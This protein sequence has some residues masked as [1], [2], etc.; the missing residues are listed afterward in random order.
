MRP[1][2]ELTRCC[3]LEYVDLPTLCAQADI[4]S[5]HTPLTAET[6]HS[7]GEE[8]LGQHEA[9]RDAHQHRPGWRARHGCRPARPARSQPG[10]LGL[11]V[12]EG[13]ANLFFADHPRDPLRDQVLAE[14]L[15][16]DNVLITAHQAFL[17]R[18][19]LTS[20]G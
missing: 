11:N 8:V 14:L 1:N 3:G 19:A 17:T 2:Q 15:T 4:I 7:F 16:Y 12:Y 13:E 20:L 9:R 5:R 10:Y 6:R 18:E